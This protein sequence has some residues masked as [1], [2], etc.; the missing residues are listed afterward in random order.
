MVD[1][2]AAYLQPAHRAQLCAKI[3]AGEH[4]S[5]I[6]ELLVVCA[7]TQAKLPHEIAA[8]IRNWIHGYAGSDIETSL[9][10]FSR[11]SA[12]TLQTK[13]QAKHARPTMT[14]HPG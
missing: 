6:R 2:I 11:N 12:S 10:T 5:A 7:R 4:D 13:P 1:A 14:D 9:Q 8:A 3:G